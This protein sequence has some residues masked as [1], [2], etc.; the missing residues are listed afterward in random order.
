MIFVK[1]LYS[2]IQYSDPEYLILNIPLLVSALEREQ[3]SRI[4]DRTKHKPNVPEKKAND[5]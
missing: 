4:D 5:A 2:V 3:S 1:R